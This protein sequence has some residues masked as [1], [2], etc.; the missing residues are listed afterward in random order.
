MPVISRVVLP[1]WTTLD[2]LDLPKRLYQK[3]DTHGLEIYIRNCQ[4]RC[5]HG[6]GMNVDPARVILQSR[7]WL[8]ELYRQ[9]K[10]LLDID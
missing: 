6:P 9:K 7:D 1:N 10:V 8:W 3:G 4:V 5:W 2:E